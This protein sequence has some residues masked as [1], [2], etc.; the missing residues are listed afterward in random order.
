[1]TLISIVSYIPRE[2]SMNK[3]RKEQLKYAFL[4]W[5]GILT[6]IIFWFDGIHE[7]L[8]FTNT[9]FWVILYAYEMISLEM[10]HLDEDSLFLVYEYIDRRY[11]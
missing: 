6:P 2:L 4:T 7:G 9:I 11:E 1:M 3:L 8:V 10:K 5:M